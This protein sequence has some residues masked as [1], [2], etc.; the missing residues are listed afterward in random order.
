MTDEDAADLQERFVNI[1]TALI[2]TRE[3]PVA[4]KPRDRPLNDPALGAE[5]RA[6]LGTTVGDP[7][8]YASP[9]QLGALGAGVVGAVGEE[10]FGRKAAVWTHGRYAIDQVA[11][12]RDVVAVGSGRQGSQ[13]DAVARAD[14]VML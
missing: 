5:A 12:L 9:A 1:C 10:R 4:V 7:G 13:R 3:A 14:Q 2:A 8:H 11:Q 6:M